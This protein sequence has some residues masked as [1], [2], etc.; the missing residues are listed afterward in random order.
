MSQADKVESLKQWCLNY[1]DHF[2][3]EYGALSPNEQKGISNTNNF[4]APCQIEIFWVTNPD[5]QLMIQSNCSDRP[6]RQIV[7]HGPYQP[8]E[9]RSNAATILAERWWT[10]DLIDDSGIVYEHARALGEAM[11][12]EI[13][14][15]VEIIKFDLFH[16][17]QNAYHTLYGMSVGDIWANIYAGNIGDLDYVQEIDNTIQ[18]I[19]CASKARQEQKSSLQQ[20]R[21]FTAVTYMGF[22]AHFFP[23][24]MLGKKRKPTIEQRINNQP[25]TWAYNNMAFSMEIN[26]HKVIVNNDGLV[27]VETK[28][29]DRALK[30]LNLVMACSVF[31][32]LNSHAVH[33]RE[34]V[35]SNYDKQNLALTSMQWNVETRRTPLLEDRFNL[36]STNLP[37]IQVKPETVREILSNTEKL[38]TH[39]RLSDDMR[40]FNEGLTHF[41][42]SEF[43]QSFIMGWSVIERYYT[44]LWKV[45]LSKKKITKKRLGKLTNPS[46]WTFDVILEFLNLQD[47]IDD[48]LY[49]RLLKLK[50]RR[51]KFYHEGMSVTNDDAKLCLTHAKKLISKSIKPFISISDNLILSGRPSMIRLE[52]G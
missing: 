22:G 51:N 46:Q 12:E 29:K 45:L 15:F 33:E 41:A 26:G 21:P 4:L 7:I 9:F 25:N 3:K 39:E 50:S 43:A 13:Y 1:I 35:M 14:K 18:E 8:H 2:R 20:P 34:L 38:L 32:H 23:P 47:V 37:R 49:D 16:P 19:K 40:L 52:D 36:R 6:D 10:R 24:I 48:D 44:A 17:Q 11:A 30:I 5:Y 31:Y 27:F 42:N 28:D